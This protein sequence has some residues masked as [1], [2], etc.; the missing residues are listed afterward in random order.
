MRRTAPARSQNLVETIEIDGLRQK[1]IHADLAR[2]IDRGLERIGRERDDAGRQSIG[3][4]FRRP[5]APRDFDA[6]EP[7]H[8]DVENDGVECFACAFERGL[9]RLPCREPVVDMHDLRAAP[10]EMPLDDER[11]DLI[12]FGEKHR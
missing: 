9:R 12:V 2:R 11:I 1:H 4:A 5:Q 10:R 8:A 6:V 7:G 3:G